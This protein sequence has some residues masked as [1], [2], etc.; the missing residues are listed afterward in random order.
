MLACLFLIQKSY[1]TN[2]KALSHQ[3]WNKPQAEGNM[4]SHLYSRGPSS[5]KL[6]EEYDAGEDSSTLFSNNKKFIFAH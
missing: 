1:F 6:H 4:N 3:K 5:N 2:V